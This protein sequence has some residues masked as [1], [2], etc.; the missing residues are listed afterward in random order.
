MPVIEMHRVVT[1]TRSRSWSRNIFLVSLTLL[2]SSSCPKD[3]H[4]KG[5]VRNT[6]ILCMHFRTYSMRS[7]RGGFIFRNRGPSLKVHNCQCLTSMTKH[8][9]K[10]PKSLIH[11]KFRLSFHG[12]RDHWTPPS[13]HTTATAGFTAKSKLGT[14]TQWYF[15]L[16]PYSVQ[17]SWRRKI[18][19][20]PI[21]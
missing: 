7:I 12:T 14:I 18:S 3:G 15:K 1:W 19:S 8:D 10:S 13:E 20:I 2:W 9:L 4:A 11:F 21:S 5:S 6:W 17:S 16:K